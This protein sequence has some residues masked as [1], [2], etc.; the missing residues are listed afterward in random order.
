MWKWLLAL[1]VAIGGIGLALFYDVIGAAIDNALKI[2]IRADIDLVKRHKVGDVTIA[3]LVGHAATWNGSHR[4]ELWRTLV[5]CRGQKGG[6]EVVYH[7]E[8]SRGFAPHDNYSP[9][10]GIFITPLTRAT[11]A[12][13]PALVP[14]EVMCELP[15]QPGMSAAA[16][17]QA[18]GIGPRPSLPSLMPDR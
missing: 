4:D 3:A 8:V 16:L 2:R 1:C 17:Y 18:A 15:A 7:W 11:G 14:K 5:S 10:K 13:T 6:D 9:Q 12:I